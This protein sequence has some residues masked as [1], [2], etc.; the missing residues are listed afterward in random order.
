MP[1]G[2]LPPWSRPLLRLRH[3]RTP[4]TG[5]PGGRAGE[6]ELAAVPGLVRNFP[7]EA[8]RAPPPVR[9]PDVWRGD[10]TYAT[11]PDPQLLLEAPGFVVGSHHDDTAPESSAVRRLLEPATSAM[12]ATHIGEQ[13]LDAPDARLDTTMRPRRRNRSPVTPEVPPGH[14]AEPGH[15]GAPQPRLGGPS[16][17]PAG[18]GSERP[19]PGGAVPD[20]RARRE[21][22]EAASPRPPLRRRPG[23]FDHGER[24][25]HPFTPPCK[26]AASAPVARRKVDGSGEGTSEGGTG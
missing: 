17:P 20:D 2:R 26:G 4:A 23:V 14:R 6:G 24:G 1:S 21:R 10:G 18:P 5:C 22:R 19:D 25:S 16:G 8:V 7:R 13:Q 11:G 9:M 3:R 12:A 15:P